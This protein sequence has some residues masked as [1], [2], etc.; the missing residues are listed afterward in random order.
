MK[1]TDDML[2]EEFDPDTKP[3]HEGVYPTTK[4]SGG[5][6]V[7]YSRWADGEWKFDE[8]SV[9]GAAIETIRSPFQDRRWRGLK[10][11]HHG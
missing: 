10:E 6:F 2:T 1:I 3:V 4:I 5:G 8:H 7:F 11:K 9:D